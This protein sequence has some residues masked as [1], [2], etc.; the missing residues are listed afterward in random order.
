MILRDVNS[1]A[2]FMAFSMDWITRF[3][4]LPRFDL[5]LILRC[6]NGRRFVYNTSM[7]S[8][9]SFRVRSLHFRM[10]DVFQDGTLTNF[11]HSYPPTMLQNGSHGRLSSWSHALPTKRSIC[12]WRNTTESHWLNI[13][14]IAT[15]PCSSWRQ[16]S[17]NMHLTTS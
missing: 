14:F 3:T 1:N 8:F 15:F 6:S 17:G 7:F 12:C 9:N 13:F 16:E 5:R 11:P 2:T 10:P 4:H